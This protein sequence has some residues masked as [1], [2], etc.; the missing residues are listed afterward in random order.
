MQECL[1]FVFVI[2]FAC[3]CAFVGF[4]LTLSLHFLRHGT[5]ATDVYACLVVLFCLFVCVYKCVRVYVEA[6]YN[7]SKVHNLFGVGVYGNGTCH[8]S[9]CSVLR[10]AALMR[11]FARIVLLLDQVVPRPKCNQM[12]VVGRSWNG[13][14]SRTPHVRVTQL[15]R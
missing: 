12:C 3:F 14:G 13:N 6:L 2:I 4:D 9:R 5:R 7:L 15:I 1:F 10:A 8:R 11:S